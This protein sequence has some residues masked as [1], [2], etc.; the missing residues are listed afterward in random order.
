MQT[1]ITMLRQMTRGESEDRQKRGTWRSVV[2]A[3]IIE[4]RV[5]SS[6]PPHVWRRRTK[7]AF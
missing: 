4:K 5:C 7:E 3:F 2:S 1:V 6:I